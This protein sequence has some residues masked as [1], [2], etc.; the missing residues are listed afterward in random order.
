MAYGGSQAGG[1]TWAV[2]A[3]QPTPQPQQSEIRVLSATYT[4]AHGKARSLTYWGRP[5]IKPETSCSWSDSLT[6]ELRWELHGLR[7][8]K[9]PSFSQMI[10]LSACR[11]NRM[12]TLIFI[13]SG[14]NKKLGFFFFRAFPL[15]CGSSQ[16]RGRIGA[17]VTGTPDHSHIWDLHHN[18]QATQDP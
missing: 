7:I 13:Y 10:T 5:G 12:I 15:A 6:T 8:W 17:A 1:R 14:S 2:A 11:T 4:T 3:S 9:D 18:S 16:P